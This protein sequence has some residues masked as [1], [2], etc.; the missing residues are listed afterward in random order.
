[1]LYCQIKNELINSPQSLPIA[2][3]NISNFSSLPDQSLRDYG[4][5]PYHESYPP[6]YDPMTQRLSKFIRNFFG[7]SY[8]LM[9]NSSAIC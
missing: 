9:A 6:A 3:D 7:R 8:G 4:W 1:M 5:Y 2:H